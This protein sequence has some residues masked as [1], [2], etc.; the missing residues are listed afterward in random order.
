MPGSNIYSLLLT[1]GQVAALSGWQSLS[2]RAVAVRHRNMA[3]DSIAH[4]HL[5]MLRADFNRAALVQSAN[6]VKAAYDRR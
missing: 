6:A 3:Q 5:R 4:R 2:T 1:L